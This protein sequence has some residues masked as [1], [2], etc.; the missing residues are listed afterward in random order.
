VEFSFI[1][2]EQAVFPITHGC[3]VLGMSRAGR[4]EAH[5]GWR[6]LCE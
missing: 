5:V 2:V 1:E 4:R 6:L 3:G